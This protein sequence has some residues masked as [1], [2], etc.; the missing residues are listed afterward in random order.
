MPAEE[1]A[2]AEGSRSSEIAARSWRERPRFPWGASWVF[3]EP[4]GWFQVQRR[5]LSN[6]PVQFAT[7]SVF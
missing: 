6:L 3:A 1:S 5:A 4:P 7:N 2:D